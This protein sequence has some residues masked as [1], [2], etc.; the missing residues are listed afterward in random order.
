MKSFMRRASAICV[1]IF[2]LS[3]VSPAAEATPAVSAKSLLAKIKVRSEHTTGYDRDYFK[4]WVDAN[5]NGC[6]TRYEVL[7]AEA[8]TKPRVSGSCYLAGGKWVSKYDGIVFT[9][10]RLMDIDHMVPLAEAWASGAYRWSAATREAFANDL[11]YSRS[12]IGVS[13]SSNRSKSDKDPWIWMPPK[14]AYACQYIGDWIAIKYRWGLSV[15]STERND[16]LGKLNRCG[17]RAYLVAP[18][19]AIVLFSSTTNSSTGSSSG[20]TGSSNGRGNDP[21]YTSCKMAKASGFGP[22]YRGRDSEYSWYRDGD[23]DGIACE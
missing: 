15:D 18:L 12:L 4:L 19:K 20:S 6:N 22:Y 11:G 7:I 17:K 2:A 13:A 3:L 9:N 1:S 10:P 5:R 16:L 23:S 14:S 8:I 21:R